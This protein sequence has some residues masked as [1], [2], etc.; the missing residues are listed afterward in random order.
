MHFTENL[1]LEP[2]LKLVNKQLK[3]LRK[4]WAK[5]NS[6]KVLLD[7]HF[8]TK[9]GLSLNERKRKFKKLSNAALSPKSLKK[10]KLW[11]NLKTFKLQ[12]FQM[13]KM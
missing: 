3:H 13:I 1:I 8:K 9:L 11:N 4:E 5:K 10:Q 12:N 7:W 6:S 2:D